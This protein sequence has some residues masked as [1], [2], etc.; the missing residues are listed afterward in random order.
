MTSE[1]EMTQFQVGKSAQK[2]GKRSLSFL[3]LSI[4]ELLNG[5][6]EGWLRLEDV[7]ELCVAQ[8]NAHNQTFHAFEK[9]D[10][11]ILR[12]QTRNLSERLAT[13]G[14]LRELEGIPV[15]IKD[16]FNTVEFETEMGSPLWKGFTPGNDARA[17]FNLKR[18]GAIVPGKTVTAEFAVHSLLGKSINPHSPDR[19]PG[20][21]SSGSAVAIA[22]GMVPAA[23]GSQTAGS[24]IRPAS[25]CGV[26]GCKPSFGLIPRTGVLKT[27]DTLDNLGFFVSRCEDLNRMFDSLRLHG[28]DYP[29][30]DRLLGDTDRQSKAPERPWR[31]AFLKTHTWDSAH[32]YARDSLVQWVDSIANCDGIEVIEVELPEEF[33]KAHEIHEVIYNKC[34]AYYFEREFKEHTL[35]S[36]TMI[37]LIECGLRITPAEYQ[38]ALAE[39]ESL[40]SK[41]DHL[42]E[43]Y[44]V[45]VSFSTAGEAPL[46]GEE[47]PLDP[48]LIWTLV[49]MP[50]V[51]AP[52][53]TGPAGL[54]FG[55]QIGARRYNDKLLFSF[56]ADLESRGLVPVGPNPPFQYSQIHSN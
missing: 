22:T 15:G 6:N 44:D 25:Y 3:K 19:T 9:F 38:T 17:V 43:S 10:A 41:M 49:Y 31:V 33:E 55:A 51:N 12:T 1:I 46:I 47:E 24:I 34:L 50:T 40:V 27:T 45:T 14:S 53:F 39:Q 20:T 23:L 18:E 48:S 8:V 11:E 32:G 54:P 4:K 42:L 29:M 26:Y 37:D 35:V 7:T 52:I 5:Y 28:A 2:Q 21:S 16:I 56:I 30:I 13:G 36:E